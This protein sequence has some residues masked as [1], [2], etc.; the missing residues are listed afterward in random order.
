VNV[1]VFEKYPSEITGP[2]V[3]VMVTA[4]LAS[5][6]VAVPSEPSGSAGLQPRFISS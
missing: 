5:V 1:L 6:A 3:D 4:P 2:S